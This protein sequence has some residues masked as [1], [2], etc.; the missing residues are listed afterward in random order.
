MSDCRAAGHGITLISA[1]R[2]NST[3]VYLYDKK[4]NYYRNLGYDEATAKAK[5]ATVVAVPGTSEHEL[6][7]AVDLADSSYPYLDEAQEKTDTQKWLMEHCW[8]YGFILR[9]PNTKTESTG[10]IYEPWHY[11]YVGKDVAMELR[12][13]GQ[14][15]EEYLNSLQ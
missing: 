9:Y 5:A 2:P 15:L 10:I 6:G 13:S 7:L 14:S 4:V 1:Y 12:S 11:R 8:E 3:Q